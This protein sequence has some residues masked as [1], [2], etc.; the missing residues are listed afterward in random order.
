MADNSFDT[1]AAARALE[2]VGIERAQAEAI[3][4]AINHKAELAWLESLFP[5]IRP[6]SKMELEASIALA[7]AEMELSIVPLRTALRIARWILGLLVS[8]IIAVLG[9]VASGARFLDRLF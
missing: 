5:P 6:V 9:L 3:A 2:E 1:V 4:K 7:K 8:A